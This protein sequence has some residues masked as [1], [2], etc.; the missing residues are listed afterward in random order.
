MVPE[1]IPGEIMQ[2]NRADSMNF[3]EFETGFA[4]K[5]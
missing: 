4:D 3:L 1:E 2:P 5:P